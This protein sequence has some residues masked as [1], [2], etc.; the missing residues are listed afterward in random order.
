MTAF[1]HADRFSVSLSTDHTPSQPFDQRAPGASPPELFG[2]VGHPRGCPRPSNHQGRADGQ[3]S[4]GASNPSANR[5]SADRVRL[6]SRVDESRIG[7]PVGAAF[8]ELDGL[9]TRAGAGDHAAFE[10][11]YLATRPRVTAIAVRVLRNPAIASEAVQEC[12]L[13]V[14]RLSATFDAA[15][16]TAIGWIATIAHRRS[17]DMVR[18]AQAS[19]RR[20]V[21]HGIA[22]YCPA[23]RTSRQQPR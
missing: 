7:Q 2:G 17:V 12:F 10:A 1:L 4:S 5:A 11:L 15:R 9:L 22:T 13:D 16:G 19:L 14:W 6:P 20:E 18:K 3:V 23:T 8:E 21:A